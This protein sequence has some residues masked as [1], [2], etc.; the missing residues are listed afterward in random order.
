MGDNLSAQTHTDERANQ[1][2]SDSH[3]QSRI[4]SQIHTDERA[5]HHHTHAHDSRH[6][7]GHHLLQVEDLSLSF[8]MY[9]PDADSFFGAKKREITVL[10]HLSISVHAGEIVAVIGASGSGKSLLADTIM[11]LFEP[12]AHVSGRIWFDG[13][14]QDARSLADLRGQGLSL[15][16]QSVAYLDPL[17]K[18]GRQVRGFAK[19]T[20]GDMRTERQTRT[21]RCARAER[22]VDSSCC[23][24][25]QRQTREERRAQ[26]TR[27]TRLK[28]RAR[29]RELFARYDLAPEV[30]NLYPHELS[31]GMARRVLLCCAL[32]EN[33]RVII[34]D[35]PTPGLD[36][37]L[38]VRALD[39]LR[40][41]ADEGGGVML[42]THDIELA[43]RVADRVAVFRD[44]SIVEETSVDAF[45]Q[46]EMLQHPFSR[47]LW[48][49]LPEHDFSVYE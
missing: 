8:T 2:V 11:G 25:A 33:P 21:Q 37:E 16:P 28:R 46:P 1:P 38:A 18:V 29:A 4:H 41:F 13:E 43:L 36:L 31:G 23:T 22:H 32:M 7:C 14:L 27:R 35:E 30:E 44:G 3:A 10:D 5:H 26:S 24:H 17:M 49:A 42:I 12:N 9:D 40:A 39:D 19:D 45:S 20:A 34:A 48:H 15:M 47:A 6:D